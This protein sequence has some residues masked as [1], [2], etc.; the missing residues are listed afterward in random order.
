M[1]V[2][3]EKAAKDKERYRME[4]ERYRERLRT[5]Q[6][7]MIS[8]AVP[9]Q[10]LPPIEPSS[11]NEDANANNE[12]AMPMQPAGDAKMIDLE[13]ECQTDDENP[14]TKTLDIN[15]NASSSGMS[16]DYETHNDT[17]DQNMELQPIVPEIEDKNNSKDIQKSG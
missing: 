1:Q 16:L 2:Y 9:I 7:M 12:S 6:M 8:N 11:I 4:M 10:Q 3:Q 5:G 14:P 17:M 13:K 15:L